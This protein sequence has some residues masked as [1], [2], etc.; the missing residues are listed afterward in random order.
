M[1]FLQWQINH[2]T[3][4]LKQAESTKAK[5]FLRQTL[6]GLKKCQTTQSTSKH[7]N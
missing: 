3:E 5:S 6:K 1:D 2:Y 7:N 4:R